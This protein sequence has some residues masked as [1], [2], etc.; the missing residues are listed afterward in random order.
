MAVM[1]SRDRPRNA[2]ARR[3][4]SKPPLHRL[5]DQ[6][7]Q[8]LFFAREVL[9]DRSLRVLQRLGDSIHAQ[10]VVTVLNDHRP[11]QLEDSSLAALCISRCL[12]VS[13]PF[14]THIIGTT[15]VF[16][17]RSVAIFRDSRPCRTSPTSLGRSASSARVRLSLALD[18]RSAVD[19]LSGPA[20]AM[21]H[22]FRQ[23][24]RAESRG[25]ALWAQ[26]GRDTAI[27]DARGED[28]P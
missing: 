23:E 6:G 1:R 14:M 22:E 8:D 5:V 19:V 17:K 4:R 21:K 9:V 24:L 27:A 25:S 13:V 12:R 28:L 26:D 20:S 3:N 10:T 7:H 16:D 11:G 18:E 2:A 15:S